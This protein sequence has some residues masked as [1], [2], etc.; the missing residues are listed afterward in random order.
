[1]FAGCAAVLVV[2]CATVLGAVC[3]AVFANK[4]GCA[5]DLAA[6]FASKVGCAAGLAAVF[7]ADGLY[8]GDTYSSSYS[9]PQSSCSSSSSQALD[10]G[11][12]AKTA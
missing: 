10:A 11:I 9:D 4:V 5:A 1:M 3:A 12:G 8:S 7:E 2:G 6:V